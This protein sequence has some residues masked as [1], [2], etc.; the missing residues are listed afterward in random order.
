MPVGLI[1]F[2][3]KSHTDLHGVLTLT[4]IIFTLTVFN[5]ASRNTTNFW[6]LLDYI[7]NLSY[8]KKGR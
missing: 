8:G 2:G 5:R 4:P 7:P 3:D 6:R 1:L